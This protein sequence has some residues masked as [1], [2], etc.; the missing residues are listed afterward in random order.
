M[1]GFLRSLPRPKFS[2][3]YDTVRSTSESTIV[4]TTE[5]PYRSGKSLPESEPSLGALVLSCSDLG[6]EIQG[7]DSGP[8]KLTV[9]N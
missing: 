9:Q 5:K 8:S 3:R 4:L 1:R 6:F 7:A 2:Q